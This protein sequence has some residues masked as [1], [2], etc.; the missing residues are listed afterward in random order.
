MTAFAMLY[1]K[2]IFETATAPHGRGRQGSRL[3]VIEVGLGYGMQKSN[4]PVFQSNGYCILLV[5]NT[6]L[7][8]SPPK[9][10]QYFRGGKRFS[11]IV[12]TSDF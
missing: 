1:L 5:L 6:P 7:T 9:A 10:D 12:L 11:F 2:K 8:P 3:P 4:I